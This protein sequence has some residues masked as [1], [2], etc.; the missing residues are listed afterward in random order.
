MSQP[1]G[2]VDPARPHFVCKL[3]R[4]RYGLKQGPRAWF[5]R[6]STYLISHGFHAAKSDASLFVYRHSTARIY[7]LVYVDDI[8][9]TSNHPPSIS[10]LI[11]TLKSKFALKDLGP[12]H[13]FL[14]VEA[15]LFV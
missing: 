4:S 9:V 11:S 3:R 5:T 14:G 12:L 2:F 6:L 15:S 13:Y 10:H 1:Q 7:V 8:L